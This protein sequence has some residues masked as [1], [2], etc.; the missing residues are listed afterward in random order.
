[1]IWSWRE[2]Q[3]SINAVG[4]GRR[5][6]EYTSVDVRGNNAVRVKVHPSEY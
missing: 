4:E 3:A 1:M 2:N 5:L 6:C